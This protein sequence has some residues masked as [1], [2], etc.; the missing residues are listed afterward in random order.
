MARLSGPK[1]SGRA[2]GLGKKSSQLIGV[3]EKEKTANVNETLSL[4]KK[5]VG[6]KTIVAREKNMTKI[7]LSFLKKQ[8]MENVSVNVKLD[9]NSTGVEKYVSALVKQLS[10]TSP[11]LFKEGITSINIISRSVAKKLDPDSEIGQQLEAKDTAS[12]EVVTAVNFDPQK[13]YPH[14]M[15]LNVYVPSNPSDTPAELRNVIAHELGHVM[16]KKWADSLMQDYV[17]VK[18]GGRMMDVN[19]KRMLYRGKDV[20]ADTR[21]ALKILQNK[22]KNDKSFK[23]QMAFVKDWEKVSAFGIK[24]IGVET[25]VG[26]VAKVKDWVFNPDKIVITNKNQTSEDVL[27]AAFGLSMAGTYV[28]ND[29]KSRSNA[30]MLVSPSEELAEAVRVAREPKFKE[31]MDNLSKTNPD[32]RNYLEGLL[33]VVAKHDSLIKERL[34][35]VSK[36]KSVLSAKAFKKVKKKLKRKTLEQES[37][38]ESHSQKLKK[39]STIPF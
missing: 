25:A 36:D 9:K 32:A 8:G 21:A 30:K 34:N 28:F 2:S 14:D 7:L 22:S 27:R 31:H 38:I 17:L 18:T 20:D 10:E 19:G 29:A 12:A 33:K 3:R 39:N 13:K 15:Y 16:E 4:I 6:A 5:A 11:T 23:S 35:T 37:A 24:T 1:A 26:S